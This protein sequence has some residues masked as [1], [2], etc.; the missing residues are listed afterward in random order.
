MTIQRP[1][2]IHVALPWLYDDGTSV[3]EGTL[4]G[5][6]HDDNTVDAMTL[7]LDDGDEPSLRGR[8]RRDA[9]GELR[10]TAHDMWRR[11]V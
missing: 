7:L 6:V 8:D 4:S 11:A 1:N 5:D 9:E 2:P 3:R 10:Q